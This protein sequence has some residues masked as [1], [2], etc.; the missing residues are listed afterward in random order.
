MKIPST[1]TNSGRGDVVAKSLKQRIAQK[2]GNIAAPAGEIVVDTKH[3]AAL[4]EKTLAKMRSEK[5][6]AARNQNA[7]SAKPLGQEE[8]LLAQSRVYSRLYPKTQE[9]ES[10]RK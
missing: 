8:F 5:N 7:L 3:L 10:I 6:G 1:S 4:F 2:V 9:N